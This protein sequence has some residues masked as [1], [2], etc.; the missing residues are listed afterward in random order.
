MSAQARK[1]ES[2]ASSKVMF[3]PSRLETETAEQ[4]SA[5]PEALIA[6]GDLEDRL[7]GVLESW[8]AQRYIHEAFQ[9]GD[10]PDDPFDPVYISK[11]APDAIADSDIQ[12]IEK[13]AGIQDLSDYLVFEDDLEE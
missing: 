1:S 6:F 10:S 11:L 8:V 4:S 13:Y 7:K 2:T 3:F 9:L 5:L 12:R